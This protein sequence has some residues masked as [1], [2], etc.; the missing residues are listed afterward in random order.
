MKKLL[1]FIF[2]IFCAGIVPAKSA[3]LQKFADTISSFVGCPVGV[4]QI[5]KDIFIFSLGD[6]TVTERFIEKTREA[7]I[8]D[9]VAMACVPQQATLKLL[10]QKC[11]EQQ[12]TTVVA[13]TAPAFRRVSL[14]GSYDPNN[15]PLLRQGHSE[16]GRL[17]GPEIAASWGRTIIGSAALIGGAALVANA[18]KAATATAT[19]TAV[20][21]NTPASPG[22]PGPGG[23]PVLPPPPSLGFP[24]V[25]GTPINPFPGTG[26]VP[27]IP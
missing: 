2:V 22:F 16:I 21:E 15:D 7:I 17:Q 18:T 25:G 10:Q 4:Q 26:G 9:G 27:I 13:P 24:G 1:F 14:L 23:T 12:K 3:D 5:E 20:V 11:R 6:F 19:A 8:S